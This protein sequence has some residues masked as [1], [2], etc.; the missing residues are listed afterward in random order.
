[1]PKGR[2]TPFGQIDLPVTFGT[3]TNFKIETLTFKVVGLQ[4]PITPSLEGHATR[5]LRLFPTI[6]T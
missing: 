4:G 6:P 2:M 1:M 3:P 5:S